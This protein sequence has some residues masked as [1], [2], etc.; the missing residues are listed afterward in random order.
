[1]KPVHVT[2][3]LTKAQKKAY[4]PH[5]LPEFSIHRTFP[6]E[7]NNKEYYIVGQ[8]TVNEQDQFM[9]W[10]VLDGEGR[11]VSKEEAKQIHQVYTYWLWTKKAIRLIPALEERLSMQPEEIKIKEV[12]NRAAAKMEKDY[13]LHSAH[14][15]MEFLSILQSKPEIEEQLLDYL[16]PLK[17]IIEDI[18]SE[19]RLSEQ[20]IER[21][22]PLWESF[23]TIYQSWMKSL[24]N[25]EVHVFL[26]NRVNDSKEC[27]EESRF[28]LNVLKEKS[29]MY[30][31]IS[32]IGHLDE[33]FL[34]GDLHQHIIWHFERTMAQPEDPKPDVS[35]KGKYKPY[36]VLKWI[37]SALVYAF[38]PLEALLFLFTW[39]IGIL[40]TMGMQLFIFVPIIRPY[41]MWARLHLI[42]QWKEIIAD[43]S[44]VLDSFEAK[45]LSV[46]PSYRVAGIFM[47]GFG[48]VMYFFTVLAVPLTFFG[49]GAL[50]YGYG[51]LVSKTS[52]AWTTVEFHKAWIKIGPNEFWG[53]QIRELVWEEENT[54]K[55]DQGKDKGAFSIQ[56]KP[57]DKQAAEQA[58]TEWC[59]IN[60][61][62]V[63]G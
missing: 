19:K 30:S 58:L 44:M 18:E 3:K 50:L 34:E 59:Q 55:I 54:L 7:W 8:F 47:A 26:R 51:Q 13:G 17:K 56:F 53:M 4:K 11:V 20:H 15:I 49:I 24:D 36:P 14:K 22:T 25:F 60:G 21:I 39:N 37:Y 62:S 31:I 5:A 35:F 27:E 57:E 43:K 2:K 29:L 52:L 46:A 61:R 1:M 40:I 41:R 23:Q 42:F 38:I 45:N 28:V 10:V 33:S 9:H 16:H 48:A 12:I 6:I 63:A 32:V